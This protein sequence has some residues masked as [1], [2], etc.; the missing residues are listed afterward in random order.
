LQGLD[1]IEIDRLPVIFLGHR[2]EDQPDALVRLAVGKCPAM[3]GVTPK[4]QRS[5]V[6]GKRDSSMLFSFR[7]DSCGVLIF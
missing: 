4:L 5:G 6:H 2:V 7:M 3:L 1:G